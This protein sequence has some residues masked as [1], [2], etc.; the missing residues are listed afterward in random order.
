MRNSDTDNTLFPVARIWQFM[1]VSVFLV[2]LMACGEVDENDGEV[3][4]SFNLPTDSALTLYC[5][6]AGIGGESCILDDPENPYAITPVN[7][8]TKWDLSDDAPSWKARFYMWATAQAMSPRGE[9]QY[10]VALALQGMYSESGSELAREQALKAYRSVLDNYYD[11]VW[12][13]KYPAPPATPTLYLWPKKVRLLSVDN[14]WDDGD[15]DNPLRDSTSQFPLSPLFASELAAL[16]AIGEWG[17]TFESETGD[18]I[19]N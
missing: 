19:P 11:D 13:F 14:L 15:G 12:F 5:P 18:I 17:Y 1:I 9:N 7:D 6:D 10:H 16:E 8:T 4:N 3:V 2:T